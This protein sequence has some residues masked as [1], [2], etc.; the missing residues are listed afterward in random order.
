MLSEEQ[1]Q[2]IVKCVYEQPQL[3]GCVVGYCGAGLCR[4]LATPFC[5]SANSENV[6]VVL[7]ELVIADSSATPELQRLAQAG[8]GVPRGAPGASVITNRSRIGPE[9]IGAGIACG[10][11][12]VSALG[13]IG[14]VA[15]EV[16]TGGAST[17]LVVASW[18]G[19]TTGG[20]QCANG[21]VRVGAILYDPD[22]DSLSRWDDNSIY[23]YG[24]LLVD[25]LG[26]ATGVAALPFAVRNLW[27]VIAR[28]RTFLAR[29][30][31]LEALKRMNRLERL[32]VI[33]ICFEE[34]ARTPE[35]RAALVQAAREADIGAQTM[36]RAT[37]LSV[38]HADTLRRII[39]DETVRRLST[40]LRDVIAGIVGIGASSAPDRIVGSASGS[41]S[42]AIHLLD[43]GA[44][45]LR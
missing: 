35:G 27:A 21:V 25:A 23:K 44:P 17:F 24:I 3:R 15:G 38:R 30:L 39:S 31:S 26:V 9:L 8:H 16:P 14:G 19:L 18:T 2:Q 11:T 41:V 32:R 34:A 37:S 36:Q 33:A 10:L 6:A 29:N 7:E 22:D 42:Y 4:E 45:N 43:A 12:F 28:Q 20:I 13:V 40:S 5:F 1:L